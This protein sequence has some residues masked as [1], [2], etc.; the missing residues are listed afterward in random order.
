[1]S[2]SMPFSGPEPAEDDPGRPNWPLALIVVLTCLAVIASGWIVARLT[3]EDDT[4]V[5]LAEPSEQARPPRERSG[6]VDPDDAEAFLALAARGL[7][8]APSLSVSYTQ[9]EEGEEAGRGWARRGVEAGVVFE[10][11][12]TT[13]EG[14]EVYRYELDDTGHLMTAERGMTGMSLL[15]PPSEADRRLCSIEFA[16]SPL[17][18]LV[19][20]ASDLV[21][22]GR[23]EITLPEGLDGSPEGS[24]TA[25][26]YTG[27]FTAVMGGYEEESGHNTLTVLPKTEFSLWIDEEGYPRRLEYDTEEGFGETYDYRPTVD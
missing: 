12:F 21:W 7:R 19:D 8:D 15:N 11:H 4:V 26:R 6:S 22:E 18:D 25:Y 5:P 13:A 24:Y 27:D 14:V 20:S 17:D 1:M 3:L 23:E 2:T 10:H 16:L 9:R